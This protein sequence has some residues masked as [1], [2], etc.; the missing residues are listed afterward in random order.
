MSRV[1]DEEAMLLLAL[2]DTALEI[3]TFQVKLGDS[4]FRYAMIIKK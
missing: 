4:E 2:Q 1:P 3:S